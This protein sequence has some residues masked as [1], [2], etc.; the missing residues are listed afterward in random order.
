[1]APPSQWLGGIPNVLSPQE[2]EYPLID[3]IQFSCRVAEPGRPWNGW[4]PVPTQVSGGRPFGR[5]VR[6]RRSALDYIGGDRTISL[7]QLQTLLEVA[8]FEDGFVRLYVFAHRVRDLEPG[9]Y[10]GGLRRLRAGDVRLTAAALSLGQDLAGNS[11]VT[12]S[13]IA[14][15]ERAAHE[16]GNRGYRYAHFEAG[17][18]GQRLYLASEAMGFQATGIGAFY[19]DEVHACLGVEHVIYHFACGFAVKDARLES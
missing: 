3:G 10:D 16:F 13:M 4:R 19:D 6:R 12:F 8:R 11:C 5:V 14:D 15:L 7:D 2:V 1:V 9:L 18:I 17:A